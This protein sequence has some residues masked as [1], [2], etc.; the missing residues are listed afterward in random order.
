MDYESVDVTRREFVWNI[1]A[2]AICIMV[3]AFAHCAGRV[4]TELRIQEV[5]DVEK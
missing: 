2:L 3:L 5:C 1:R 4:S